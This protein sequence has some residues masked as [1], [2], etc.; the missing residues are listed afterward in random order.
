MDGDERVTRFVELKLADIVDGAWVETQDVIYLNPEAIRQLERK[1]K[2][3]I[4]NVPDDT[5]FVWG[6]VEE[7]ISKL[8]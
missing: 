4:V 5:H 6:T 3:T 8:A 1:G 2:V 7:V